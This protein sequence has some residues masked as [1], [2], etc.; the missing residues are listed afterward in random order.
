LEDRDL[1]GALAQRE[2]ARRLYL[3]A[4]NYGLR[5]LEVAYP[6]ITNALRKDPSSALSAT[7]PDDV[8]LLYWTGLAW[9]AAIS[10][11]KDD[12]FLI[13]DLP[14]VEALV[15]RALALDEAYD[16]GGVHSFLISFEMG[17]AGANAAKRA[18]QHY[19]RAL[20]LSGGKHAA[21]HVTFAEVVSVAERDRK[22]FERALRE[23]LKIDASVNPEWQLVNTVMQRRAR[24]L[25]N[26]TDRLF[27]E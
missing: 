22:E 14:A 16:N 20:E 1:Q 10:Q 9:A 15:R 5:G 17:Y 25:L 7:K 8:G 23:A 27:A 6:G 19:A 4:R 24:W 11:S 2:R 18:R 13:A 12:P 26:R 3:R 21:P